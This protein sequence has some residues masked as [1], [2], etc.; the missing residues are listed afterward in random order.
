[1]RRL[2]NCS[3][4]IVSISKVENYLLNFEHCKGKSKAMFFRKFGYSLATSWELHR[5]LTELACG[6]MVVKIE[7]RLPFGTR[8]TTEGALRTPDAR[9][10]KVRVGWF[11]DAND[12]EKIP[13]L[14]TV[15]PAKQK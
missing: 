3:N 5:A 12:P 14:I 1:M 11:F 13:R 6:S 15:I 10:P 2:P 4:A 8:I 7:E 9:N